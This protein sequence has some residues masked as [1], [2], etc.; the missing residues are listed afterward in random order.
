MNLN[1]RLREFFAETVSPTSVHS[2]ALILKVSA[3]S[4]RRVLNQLIAEGYLIRRQERIQ[5]RF[6][7]RRATREYV[8]QRKASK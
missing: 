2:L 7:A 3:G 6:A 1:S 5:R 8:Y 4:L